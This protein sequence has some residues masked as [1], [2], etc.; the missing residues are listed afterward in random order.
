M[1]EWTRMTDEFTEGLKLCNAQQHTL[2]TEI[3]MHIQSEMDEYTR[4]WNATFYSH[5]P[6][7][8]IG[9]DR[10]PVKESNVKYIEWF[11]TNGTDVVKYVYNPNNSIAWT[12]PGNIHL[13]HYIKAN[14]TTPIMEQYDSSNW[15]VH[16]TDD[17]MYLFKKNTGE[18]FMFIRQPD[19][20]K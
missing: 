4:R 17:H 8:K 13:V 12:D 11:K 7:K 16:N 20:I 3:M 2:T 1:N 15:E 5:A 10:V 6:K 19:W 14:E 9:P 18:L